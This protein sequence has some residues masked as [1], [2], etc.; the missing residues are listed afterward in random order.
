MELIKHSVYI[1][2]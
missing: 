1:S 2:I